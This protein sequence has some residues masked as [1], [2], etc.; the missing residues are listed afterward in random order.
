MNP[1]IGIPELL[2]ILILALVV[3]GPRELPLMMRKL[4]RVVGQARSMAREFQR[5]FDEL[6]REAE[7]EE[8]KKEIQALKTANPVGD[9]SRE[10]KAAEAELRELKVD[11]AHPRTGALSASDQ[12]IIEAKKAAARAEAHALA[13]D[14]TDRQVAR[15]TAQMLP[16]E[17]G[18]EPVPAGPAPRQT[19]A[20]PAEPADDPQAKRK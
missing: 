11:T 18:A 20:S 6:G 8:L 13:G 3:V 10:L 5:S 16:A 7:M 12:K 17:T 4:G 15:E 14:E 1:G 19:G 9:V 2:V